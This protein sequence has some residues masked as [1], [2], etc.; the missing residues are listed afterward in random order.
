[1][2]IKSNQ[3]K[4]SWLVLLCIFSVPGLDSI[5]TGQKWRSQQAAL[6]LIDNNSEKQA[7]GVYRKNNGKTAY[8]I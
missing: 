6:R 2:S 3:M 8:K 7:S 1:M 4:N 5:L